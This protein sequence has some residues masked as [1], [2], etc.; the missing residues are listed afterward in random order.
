MAGLIPSGTRYQNFDFLAFPSSQSSFISNYES[1]TEVRSRG[2]FVCFWP[3]L[4]NTLFSFCGNIINGYAPYT[5]FAE[6][7]KSHPPSAATSS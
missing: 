7:W 1:R 5:S 6:R 4:P 2:G 3:A